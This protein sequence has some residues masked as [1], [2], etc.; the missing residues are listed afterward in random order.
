MQQIKKR[1]KHLHYQKQCNV[2]KM[3]QAVE[4][5]TAPTVAFYYRV[6]KIVSVHNESITQTHPFGKDKILI[7]DGLQKR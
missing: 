5:K 4:V 3:Q 7:V 6:V 2:R 1:K